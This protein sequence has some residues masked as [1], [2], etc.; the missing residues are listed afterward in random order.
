MKL[1]A[2]D[3]NNDFNDEND[4]QAIVDL[5]PNKSLGQ[6]FLRDRNIIEK[7]IK[8][9]NPKEGEVIIEIGPGPGAMT[10]PLLASGAHIIAIEKDAR[11]QSTLQ[12][13]ASSRGGSLK[14]ELADALKVDWVKMVTPGLKIVGNLPYNVGTQIVLNILQQQTPTGPMT[15]MLQ[16]EVVDRFLAPPSTP[17]RGR[18]SIWR[19]LL[20]DG[21]RLFDVPRNAF[22]PPPKVTSA[23]MQITPLT[24]PRY[25]VVLPTL[26]RVL[27]TTFNQRRKMLRASLKGML[28]EQQIEALGIDPTARP[29]TLTTEEFCTLS[30][31]VV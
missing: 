25:N 6:H 29:E 31:A 30:N 19:E 24:K 14:F 17:A 12:A 28:T 11:F 1:N 18:I 15:F 9:I 26:K 4:V 10:V 8:A 16:K 22:N 3:M 23:M 2:A 27:D 13:S 21:T 20:A 7:I 5:S